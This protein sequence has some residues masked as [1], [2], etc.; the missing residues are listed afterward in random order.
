MNISS[1]IWSIADDVLHHVYDSIKYR[2]IILP[3]TLI[4]RLD[5]VLEPTRAAV[6][7]EKIRLD[8]MGL[9]PSSQAP[10]LNRAAEQAF[11][12]CSPYTL[13]QLLARPNPATQ[14]D[15]FIAYLD[16]FSENVREVL[17]RFDF[18]KEVGRLVEADRLH[19]L[20]EKF[21]D[22]RVNLGPVA[23]RDDRGRVLLPALDNHRMGTI[24]EEL[25]R[26]FNEDY[27]I[28][29]GQQ[30][31]PRDIVDLMAELVFRPVA[32]RIVDGTYLL[33]DDA[34]GTG[35]MLT[36]GEAKLRALAEEHGRQVEIHLYGQEL[37]PETYAICKADLLIKGEG[38]EAE[39]I[40]FGSTLSKDKHGRD[41]MRFDFMLANPPFGT[42]WKLDKAAMTPGDPRFTAPRTLSRGTGGDGALL[43]LPRVSDGQMLFLLNKAAKMKDTPLGSRIAD[44]HNG[45]SLFTGEAGSG[46]SNARRHIIENDWLEAVIALPLNIFYNTGI[47]TYVWV[48]SNRKPPERQG[49]VQLIDATRLFQPLRRNLGR[50]NCELTTA[51]IRK[52]VDTFMTMDADGISVV[53]PNGHFGYWRI[54]VERPL[55]LAAQFTQAR[56]DGLR[57]ASGQEALR[58]KLHAEFGDAL[59]D[60]F[61]AISPA[62][63]ERLDPDE[64][65]DAG[66][67]DEEAAPRLPARVL[68]KLLDGATWARDGRLHRAGAA[69]MRAVGTDRQDEYTAFEAAVRREAKALKLGLTAAEVK[70][71]A[72]A[73]SWRDLAAQPIVAEAHP[74]ALKAADPRSGRFA[75]T[76]NGMPMVVSYEADKML[77]DT[78]IVPFEEPGGVDAFFNREVAPHVP[79]AWISRNAT[80]VGYEVSFA[81]HFHKPV[82]PRPLTEIRAEIEVLEAQARALLDTIMVNA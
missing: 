52:V 56:V 14:Q 39:N 69:L 30:F 15:D 53:L 66:D 68:K 16:G 54:V 64:P 49:K 9:P 42:A 34:C 37:N 27:N 48:L 10:R 41:G 4:R 70:L 11:H 5:V 38:R 71:I 60:G 28:S 46:E 17:D 51:H 58:R 59:F 81:R 57:F 8:A 80:K 55:R 50:R 19:A 65:E 33:Y 40:A 43:M 31:T 21:C 35:G 72:R 44:V 20:I 82:P 13:K 79:D 73:M 61:M 76:L 24:F 67:N 77:S 23:V 62:L 63:R 22:E 45:S 25:I 3:M 2:D 12:N 18:R 6:L 1:F 36:V 75:A 32:D 74:G 26:R 78:E 7:S 29:A 47:A